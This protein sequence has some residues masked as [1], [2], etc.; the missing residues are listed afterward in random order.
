MYFLRPRRAS[1]LDILDYI[2]LRAK[3]HLL[4]IVGKCVPQRDSIRSMRWDFSGVG[5]VVHHVD[6]CAGPSATGSSEARYTDVFHMD[7]LGFGHTVAVDRQELLA[8]FMYSILSP[9][10]V[11]YRFAC[12]SHGFEGNRFAGVRSPQSTGTSSEAPA[13]CIHAF[14]RDDAMPMAT[15]LARLRILP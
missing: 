13:V 15:F 14:P 5:R 6:A 4:G 7:C 8:T 3:A 2:F 12:F 11:E 1:G 10:P 9:G